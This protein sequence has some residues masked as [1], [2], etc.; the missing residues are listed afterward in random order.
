MFNTYLNSREKRGG[1]EKKMKK[2]TMIAVI[3][4]I[5]LFV[6]LILVKP[7]IG[8]MIRAY[9]YRGAETMY[10]IIKNQGTKENTSDSEGGYQEYIYNTTGIKSD[11]TTLNL[12]F[13]GREGRAIPKGTFLKIDYSEERGVISWTIIDKSDVPKN[14]LSRLKE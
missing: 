9:K 12:T 14:L 4:I 1:T 6:A 13:Y 8:D 3:S 11:G 7:F 10:T 2:I 5:I